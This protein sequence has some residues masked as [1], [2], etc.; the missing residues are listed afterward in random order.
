[1][2]QVFAVLRPVSPFFWRTHAGAEVDLVWHDRGVAYGLEFTYADAP[3]MT[4]YPIKVVYIMKD[5]EA[6][7]VTAFPL[8]R[9]K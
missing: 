3:V 5:D 4:R 2:E 9:R 6:T 7:L 8:K 1:M